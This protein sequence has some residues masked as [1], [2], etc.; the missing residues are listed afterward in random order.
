MWVWWKHQTELEGRH[1]QARA[2]EREIGYSYCAV[3][4]FRGKLLIWQYFH[5]LQSLGTRNLIIPCLSG[6]KTVS[7]SASYRVTEDTLFLLA[8][9]P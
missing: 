4:A 6:G 2:W 8:I 5:S 7:I 3:R 9:H 1:S